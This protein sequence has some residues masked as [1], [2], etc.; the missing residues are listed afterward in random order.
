[1]HKQFI[2][3]TEGAADHVIGR[4]S[5]GVGCR[6]NGLFSKHSSATVCSMDGLEISQE[7]SGMLDNQSITCLIISCKMSRNFGL[8]DVTSGDWLYMYIIY[9]MY[10]YIYIYNIYSIH[11]FI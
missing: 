9:Y 1:M 10:M 4:P 11:K 5:H 8:L 7:S 2:D 3:Q 6:I